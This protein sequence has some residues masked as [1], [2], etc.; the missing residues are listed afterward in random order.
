MQI[1]KQSSTMQICFPRSLSLSLSHYSSH[2]EKCKCLSEST[3]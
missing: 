1:Q 2:K 3:R